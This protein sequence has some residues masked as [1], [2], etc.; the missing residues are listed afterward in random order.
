MDLFAIKFVKNPIYNRKPLNKYTEKG[1]QIICSSYQRTLSNRH[2]INYHTSIE[3]KRYRDRISFYT[4]QPISTSNYLIQPFPN[5]KQ[6]TQGVTE[7]TRSEI[8]VDDVAEGT[9]LGIQDDV[10]EETEPVENLAESSEESFEESS[11]DEES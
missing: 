3:I 1:R 11:D 9:R 8:Q 2:L 5:V 4:G 6:V 10:T 7:E